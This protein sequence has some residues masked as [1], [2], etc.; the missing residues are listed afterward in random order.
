MPGLGNLC[1]KSLSSA[2]VV[3]KGAVLFVCAHI[4]AYQSNHIKSCLYAPLSAITHPCLS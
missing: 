3:V 2:S 1:L 4:S